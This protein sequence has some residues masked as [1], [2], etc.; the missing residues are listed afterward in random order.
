MVPQTL[1][2][3]QYVQPKPYTGKTN[4]LKFIY[5]QNLGIYGEYK[6]HKRNSIKA[7]SECFKEYLLI[8]L[9][10]VDKVIGY[11]PMEIYTHI[12]EDIFLPWDFSWEISKTL[13]ALKVEYDSDH[14]VQ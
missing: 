2:S 6:E 11:T 12:K 8:D 7:L 5:K 3:Y 13:L 14:I 1:L 10:T 9:E 4:T